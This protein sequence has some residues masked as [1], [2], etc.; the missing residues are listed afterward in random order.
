MTVF[1]WIVIITLLL[2]GF[3]GF[4]NG[5]VKEVLG[6]IGIG[7]G[8]FLTIQ[9]MNVVA[10][11]IYSYFPNS[12][13]YVPYIAAFI[14][15]FST[16][17]VVYL[18]IFILTKILDLVALGLPN[19]LLGLLF[20]IF[21]TGLIISLVLVILSGFGVPGKKTRDQSKTYPYIVSLAPVTFNFI[22]HFYPG[23]K[24]YSKTLK[25]TLDNYKPT[26]IFPVNNKK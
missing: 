26:H 16:I 15:F 22:S 6:I 14:I 17:I 7:L 23:A 24:D 21:K 19:R 4:R 8:I 12:H 10:G 3:Q 20:S 9:Y 1:D 11:L 13:V 2:F 25:Q 18:L 5:L